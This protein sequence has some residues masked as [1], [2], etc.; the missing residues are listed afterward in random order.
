MV[1]EIFYLPKLQ[2]LFQM[3]EKWCLMY[4][5][6]TIITN[7]YNYKQTIKSFYTSN[8]TQLIWLL[9]F[10]YLSLVIQSWQNTAIK[11]D[12]LNFQG[13]AILGLP[14]LNIQFWWLPDQ[15]S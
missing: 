1:R 11:K 4:I 13:R 5:F 14:Q 10:L 2:P 7:F 12:G 3:E 15:T 6:F 8:Q 9:Y